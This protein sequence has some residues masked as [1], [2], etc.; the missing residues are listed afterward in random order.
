M[1]PGIY[2]HSPSLTHYL[3]LA[4]ALA[5]WRHLRTARRP[6]EAKG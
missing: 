6:L 1:Q 2:A 3:S 5:I 4:L